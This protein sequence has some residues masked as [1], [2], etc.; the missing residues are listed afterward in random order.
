V[1]TFA[2]LGIPNGIFIVMGITLVISIVL[3]IGMFVA[4]KSEKLGK[5]PDE[6]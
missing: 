5:K 2:W 4:L 3:L 1:I 6:H